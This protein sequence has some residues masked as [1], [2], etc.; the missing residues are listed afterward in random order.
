MKTEIGLTGVFLTGLILKF[1]QIP[2]GEFLLIISLGVLAMI[3]FPAAFYFFC[4]KKIKQQNLAFTIISGLFLSVI[5]IG[6]LFKLQYWQGASLYLLIG[7]IITP[8]LLFVS[9]LLLVK[10]E[11]NLKNYYKNMIVRTSILGFISLLLFSIPTE[12]LLKF[13]YWNDPEV[14][15][16]KSQQYSNPTRIYNNQQESIVE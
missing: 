15:R 2:G 3:Y 10:S 13:Q 16:L 4:D 14:A 12:T 6:V 9:Y 8:I 11:E 7:I 1:V 5:P